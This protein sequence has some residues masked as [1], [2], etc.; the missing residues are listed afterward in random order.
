MILG[1]I[2]S[3]CY[4]GVAVRSQRT[5]RTALNWPRSPMP[6]LGCCFSRK[7]ELTATTCF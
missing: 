5:G 2:V 4:A 1:F 7:A 3:P 6:Q